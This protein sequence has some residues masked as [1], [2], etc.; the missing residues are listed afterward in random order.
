MYTCKDR[1]RDFAFQTMNEV[2]GLEE[3]FKIHYLL[4]I[5]LTDKSA[6]TTAR[7]KTLVV[8]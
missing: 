6:S 8:M 1:K 5:I 2:C 7:T 3:T 4:K